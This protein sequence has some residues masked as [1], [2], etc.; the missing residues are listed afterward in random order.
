L[1]RQECLPHLGWTK[2]GEAAN[3]VDKQGGA[4]NLGCPRP[5]NGRG[6]GRLPGLSGGHGPSG[7]S[8]ARA[9]SPACP[10]CPACPERSRGE[11]VEGSEVE[12]S[13]V[14][15]PTLRSLRSLRS[16]REKRDLGTP[17]ATP[18]TPDGLGTEDGANCDRGRQECR[19]SFG[20][21]HTRLASQPDVHR[22]EG[23]L[24]SPSPWLP[25]C[26][27]MGPAPRL[28]GLRGE[29]CHRRPCAIVS[30]R[31]EA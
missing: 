16:L 19:R 10:A 1:G 3:P 12:G 15:G 8:S 28:R 22:R 26:W 7:F 20:R 31:P 23:G 6:V 11:L 4:A 2:L 14:E 30:L 5:R 9:L 25:A 17:H 27:L 29:S 21:T 13:E 18:A 24:S